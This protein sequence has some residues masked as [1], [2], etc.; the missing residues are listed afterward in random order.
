MEADQ[1]N[2][3]VLAPPRLPAEELIIQQ[4]LRPAPA[5]AAAPADKLANKLAGVMASASPSGR[6]RFRGSF[7]GFSRSFDAW[8][9]AEPPGAP[10]IS[11]SAAGKIRRTLRIQV[12]DLILD[13][14]LMEREELNPTE[15][16]VQPPKKGGAKPHQREEVKQHRGRSCSEA[17]G[18]P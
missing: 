7:V 13:P 18:S 16:G 14:G 2:E 10:P 17:P 8:R 1:Y 11:A 15:G 9:W 4:A 12:W 3:A 5:A 6:K